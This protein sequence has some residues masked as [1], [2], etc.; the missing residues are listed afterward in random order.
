MRA[1]AALAEEGVSQ[2]SLGSQPSP[3]LE[4]QYLLDEIL[5]LRVRVTLVHDVTEGPGRE[6]CKIS[7]EDRGLVRP[8]L[9]GRR[10]EVLEDLG[11]LVRVVIAGEEGLPG[12]DLGQDAAAAP[13]VHRGGV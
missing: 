10:A 3:G 12:D 8:L 9:L 7:S 11:E 6:E 2:G 1:G 4:P 13:E 5:G